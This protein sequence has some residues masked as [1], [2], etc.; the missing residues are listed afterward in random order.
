MGVSDTIESQGKIALR[1]VCVQGKLQTHIPERNSAERARCPIES[2][3]RVQDAGRLGTRRAPQKS[4]PTPCVL[5]LSSILRTLF[6][7]KL[8]QWSA[9]QL[10]HGVLLKSGFVFYDLV[11]VRL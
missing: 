8:E 10:L 2:S 4:A 3:D 7:V 5:S 9:L 6:S 11:H 1:R